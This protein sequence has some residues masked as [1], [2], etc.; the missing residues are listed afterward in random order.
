MELDTESFAIEYRFIPSLDVEDRMAWAYDLIL[1]L[2]I[3]EI[4]NPEEDAA[5]A[6]PDAADAG[7]NIHLRR[8]RQPSLSGA[9]HAG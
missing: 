6:L 5:G 4:R 8:D 1:D 2:V 9:S 7:G 3:T